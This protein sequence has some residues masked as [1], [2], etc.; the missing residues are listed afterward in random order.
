M[1]ELTS[2]AL[3]DDPFACS[4]DVISRQDLPWLRQSKIWLR[5]CLLAIVQW[6][7]AV[8]CK[9]EIFKETRAHS[10]RWPF[11]RSPDQMMTVRSFVF[12]SLHN[13]IVL[14]KKNVPEDF[15][16]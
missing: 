7:F 10:V 16:I 11:A 9:R 2:L 5:N 13:S 15:V 12:I 14:R 3:F 1:K 6:T 4:D 8:L